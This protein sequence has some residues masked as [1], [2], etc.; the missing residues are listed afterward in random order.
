ML[1]WK[2]KFR[3]LLGILMA[4]ATCFTWQFVFIPYEL[5]S[6]CGIS[7]IFFLLLSAYLVLGTYGGRNIMEDKDDDWYR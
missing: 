4:L 3:I 5:V 6:I 1:N 7:A 2:E